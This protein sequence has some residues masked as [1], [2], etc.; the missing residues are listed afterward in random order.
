MSLLLG[1]GLVVWGCQ[2]LE[3]GLAQAV[4]EGFI[5]GLFVGRYRFSHRQRFAYTPR[6]QGSAWW[7]A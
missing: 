6:K 4:A 1:L 2:C 5:V 3:D 7:Q